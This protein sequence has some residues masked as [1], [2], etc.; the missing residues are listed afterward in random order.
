MSTTTAPTPQTWTLRFKNRRTTVFLH[1]NPLQ[2]FSSIKSH[3]Y[4]ALTESPLR[5]GSGS[6]I[7]LP[8][9]P[10]DIQLGRSANMSAPGESFV[11]GEWETT[12]DEHDEE[13]EAGGRGKAK[14]KAKGKVKKDAEDDVVENSSVKDCP[15]GA[16]LRD[17]AVLAFRWEGD[18]ST[19][20]DDSWGVIL[21]NFEETY[22]D[23]D[24][25]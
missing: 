5:D 8:S 1:V 10:S 21:P 22:A 23:E 3:L 12:G 9:S 13:D 4:H 16:G 19:S 7:G 11:L 18:G 14:A 17:N 2:T 24:G 6:I 15:K 20:K 25:V